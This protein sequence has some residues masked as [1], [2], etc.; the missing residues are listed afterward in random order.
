MHLL[1]TD[2]VMPHMD[3]KELAEHISSLRPN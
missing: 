3:G 2:I 1:I